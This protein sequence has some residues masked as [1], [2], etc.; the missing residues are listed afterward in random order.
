MSKNKMVNIGTRTFLI[1]KS[2]NEGRWHALVAPMPLAGGHVYNLPQWNC[3]ASSESA[4]DEK[5][6]RHLQE[7]QKTAK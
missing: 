5:I 3:D 2:E 7:V 6:E 1:A 4:L